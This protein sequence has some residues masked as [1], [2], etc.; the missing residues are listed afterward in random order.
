MST[1]DVPAIFDIEERAY[2][3]GWTEGILRDCIRVGYLCWTVEWDQQ[4]I[5]YGILSVGAGEAHLLNLAI[6]PKF[7]RRGLGRR[8]LRFLMDV[9]HKQGAE[10]IFLEVR[11]SNKSAIALYLD[12]GFNQIGIRNDYYPTDNGREDAIMM[13]FSF[14]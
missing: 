3:H 13:A 5:G 2:E 6:D 12:Q 1:A 9:A 14:C 8:V 7:Q 11:D 10:S 4:I